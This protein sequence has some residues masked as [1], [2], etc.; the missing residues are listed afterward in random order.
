[1]SEILDS[2]S[3]KKFLKIDLYKNSFYFKDKNLKFQF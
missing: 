3:M 1:M 2:F